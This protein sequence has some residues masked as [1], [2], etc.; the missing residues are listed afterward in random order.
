M[1]D[2]R[3]LDALRVGDVI[4]ERLHRDKPERDGDSNDDN[5]A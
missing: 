5:D 1:S 4:A 3:H 2:D